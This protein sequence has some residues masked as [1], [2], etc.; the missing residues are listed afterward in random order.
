MTWPPFTWARICSTAVSRRRASTTRRSSRRRGRRSSGGSPCRAACGPPRGGTARRR[1]GGGGPR[2]RRRRRRRGGDGLEPGR[3]RLDPVAVAHPDVE[4]RREPLEQLRPGARRWSPV[5][6][7]GG[8]LVHLAAQLVGEELE[9][10]ADAEHRH[11]QL[12]GEPVRARLP[13][14]STDAG[15]RRG[16][17]RAA[18][19]RASPPA[20]SCRVDLAVDAQLAQPPRDELRVLRAEV[21]DE[22]LLGVDVHAETPLSRG[23]GP[24][25]GASPG[26]LSPP[27]SSALPSR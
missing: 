27:G 25:E 4:L 5:R 13:S 20:S 14:A 18:R 24:G 3:Q 11:A 19:R 12:E 9:A 7:R 23:R 1:S 2:R 10:V 6:T 16:R 26:G 21:E 22:D 8:R 15:R 17:R